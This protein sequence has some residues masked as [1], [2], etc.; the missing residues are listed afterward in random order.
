M[1]QEEIDIDN[2]DIES[3]LEKTEEEN[4]LGQALDKYLPEINFHVTIS[5]HI[6]YFVAYNTKGGVYF[7]EFSNNSGNYMIKAYIHEETTTKVR[8]LEIKETNLSRLRTD[9]L[10]LMGNL[11]GIPYKDTIFWTRKK[12]TEQELKILK[13]ICPKYYNID[14]GSLSFPDE[15]GNMSFT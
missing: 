11:L 10:I 3:C 7:I 13:E 6:S 5:E 14:S 4:K 12:K 1:H 9:F 8:S 15:P 2:F